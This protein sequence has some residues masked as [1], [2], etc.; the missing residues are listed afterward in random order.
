MA[1]SPEPS[2]SYWIDTAPQTRH[3]GLAGDL[4]V[5]VAIVGGGIVGLTTALLLKRA[6]RRVAVLEARG[7]GGQVTGRST[8]K[9]TAQHSLIYADLIRSFGE[10]GARL[11]AAANQTA[12]ER[13][14]A[15]IAELGID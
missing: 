1:K 3:P 5:D 13:M 8:A 11:Y 12:I 2:P 6:G 14:I 9:I 10:D 15:F 7:I 4:A